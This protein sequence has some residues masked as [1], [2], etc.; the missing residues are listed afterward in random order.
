MKIFSNLIIFSAGRE[1]YGDAAIGYVCL[2]REA[3][4]CYVKAR[5]CPE[6][7]VRDKPYT[8]IVE[9]N[10]EK[11]EIISL[12]CQDCP[13]AKGMHKNIEFLIQ[14]LIEAYS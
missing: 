2:R 3:S 1:E 8:V 14:I 13:A 11:Q 6:H 12:D 10:E 5:V 4:I 9:I 7:K